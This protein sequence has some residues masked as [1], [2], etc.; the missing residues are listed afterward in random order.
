MMTMLLYECVFAP[1]VLVDVRG[2]ACGP[3]APWK[4]GVAS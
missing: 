2:E 3:G 1:V 4:T